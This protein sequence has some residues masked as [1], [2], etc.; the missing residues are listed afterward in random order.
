MGFN[1]FNSTI[2]NQVIGANSTQSNAAKESKSQAVF[3]NFNSKVQKQVAS[4]SEHFLNVNT[5]V[6]EQTFSSSK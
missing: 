2:G 6:F 1:N 3:K 4:K 5:T